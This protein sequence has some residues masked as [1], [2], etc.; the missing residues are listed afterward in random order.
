VKREFK[1]TEGKRYEWMQG[2]GGPKSRRS[3]DEFGID[4]M[5]RTFPFVRGSGV[6]S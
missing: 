2:G 5:K 3:E 6:Y 1:W 4:R